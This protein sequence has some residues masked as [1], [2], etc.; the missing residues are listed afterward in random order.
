IDFV[1]ESDDRRDGA[2]NLFLCDAHAIVYVAEDG[3][4]EKVTAAKL[5]VEFGRRAAREHA[6][7]LLP[8]DVNVALDAVQLFFGDLRSHLRRLVR[9]ITN[10]N[11]FS[12]RLEAF[13]KLV[14]DALFKE[15]ARASAADLTLIVED[16]HQRAVDRLLKVSIGEDDVRRFAAEFERDFGEIVGRRACDQF[17]DFGRAS[18]SD[19]INTR[20]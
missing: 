17:A 8:R 9:R 2:E 11:F 15:D 5:F 12:L 10:F 3:R 18:E 1:R 7:A 20:M 16:A 19:L 13:E 14:L 4:A 6:C